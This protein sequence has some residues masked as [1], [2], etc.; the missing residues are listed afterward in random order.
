[1]G[2]LTGNLA[3]EMDW[4]WDGIIQASEEEGQPQ[5]NKGA[6]KQI[7]FVESGSIEINIAGDN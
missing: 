5:K 6:N 2:S 4:V 3:P 7:P 1:M